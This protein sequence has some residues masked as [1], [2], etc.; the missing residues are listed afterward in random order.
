MCR[1]RSGIVLLRLDERKFPNY[2]STVCSSLGRSEQKTWFMGL[3][4]QSAR[5]LRICENILV[6]YTVCLFSLNFAFPSRHYYE[7]GTA[8]YAFD[9]YLAL[10]TPRRVLQEQLEN[11]SGTRDL[12]YAFYSS[13][14]ITYSINTIPTFTIRIFLNSLITRTSH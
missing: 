8:F 4:S 7:N 2:V 1:K 9:E 5:L 14:I 13:H 12:C 10:T 3:F 6:L 11:H